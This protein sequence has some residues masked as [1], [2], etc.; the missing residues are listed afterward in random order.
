MRINRYLASCGL[1]ARRKMDQLVTSGRVAVNGH[2]IR[3]PGVPVRPGR[4][5]VEVDGRPVEPAAELAMFLLHKPS[6]VLTTMD[7]PRGRPTVAG[8]V[9]GLPFRLFPVGRLD[10]DTEGLLLL[11]NDG[12]LCHRLSHPRYGVEKEYLVYVDGAPTPQQLQT[13]EQGVRLEEGI[14]SPAR[15][16][17]PPPEGAVPHFRLVLHEGWKRQV[18]R[19]CAAVGLQVVRLIRVRYAFLTL[20]GVARGK[21]RRLQDE[22]WRALRRLTKLQ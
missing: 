9:A 8:L 13:L 19:M 2:T 17:A 15:V 5:R 18:R 11:T 22:E 10:Q 14:T 4:D 1:G 21:L 20:E 7:D 3:E 16:L 12:K 6:G